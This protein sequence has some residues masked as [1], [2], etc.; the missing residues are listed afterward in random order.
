MSE[1]T[2]LNQSPQPTQRTQ[3]YWETVTWLNKSK[4][5]KMAIFRIGNALYG[6]QWKLLENF[7]CG[8]TTGCP[9]KKIPPRQNQPT[10][11]T[12]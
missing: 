10:N 6:I 9:V 3:T 2:N 4:S 8:N 5:G 7:A 12:Q 11:N 1:Q